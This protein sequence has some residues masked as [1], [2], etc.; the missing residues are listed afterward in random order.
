M[1]AP[2]SCLAAESPDAVALHMLWSLKKGLVQLRAFCAS[3][4]ISS[5]GT[6]RQSH[7]MLDFPS[8]SWAFNPFPCA[9]AVTPRLGWGRVACVPISCGLIER[10]WLTGEHVGH[11][12][13]ETW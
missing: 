9:D 2:R 10:F 6:R 5:Q 1:K 13:R 7:S 4:Q 12:A 8:P 11:Q 3:K